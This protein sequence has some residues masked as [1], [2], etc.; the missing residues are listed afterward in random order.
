VAEEALGEAR[1][2]EDIGLQARV[3]EFRT[4]AFLF[5]QESEA[6]RGAKMLK[7][8]LTFAREYGLRARESLALI[9]MGIVQGQLG[10]RAEGKEL[11]EQGHAILRDLGWELR[12]LGSWDDATLDYW[13]GDTQL[14]AD[15]WRIV[16]EKLAAV[17]EKAYL[18]TVATQLAQSLL[19]LGESQEAEEVL[20]AAEEAGASDD[21]MTQVQIKATRARL[22][23]RRGALAEAE[24]MARDAVREA[25]AAEYNMLMPYAHLA[26]GDVLRLAGRLDE[27]AAELRSVIAFEQARGN[28]LYVGRLR[29][30]LREFEQAASP[31][32]TD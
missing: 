27:A 15:R 23:A 13:A 8:N 28:K 14:A 6:R 17:G 1:Q 7:E 16:Y 4:R 3:L 21:V 19:D 29:R 31:S 22:L 30:E 25:E 26:L 20:R 9:D 24:E 12:A 18:S 2:A 5:S 32:R 11:I 10:A